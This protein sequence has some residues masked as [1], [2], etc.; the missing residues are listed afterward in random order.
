VQRV[1]RRFALVAVAGELATEAGLTGWAQGEATTAAAH[2][3][4][5]WIEAF[6]GIGNHE[7][8]AILEHVRAFIE[9]HGSSRFES[10][11]ADRERINNRVGYIRQKAGQA[12]EY[13]IFPESFKR[14]VCKGF[15]HRQ[16]SRVLIEQGVMLHNNDSGA[17]LPVRTPDSNSLVR[18]YILTA[19]SLLSG[20]SGTDALF[21]S[22]NNRNNRNKQPEQGVQ[23]LR[24]EK[25]VTVTTVTN[26]ATAQ[27]GDSVTAVTVSQNANR[28]R[29]KPL[30]SKSAT[31]ATDRKPP[32]C[33]KLPING[34][35][36]ET[37]KSGQRSPDNYSGGRPDLT[38][39][40]REDIAVNGHD[41]K[42]C[43]QF[44]T[45]SKRQSI[46]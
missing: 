43:N 36:L 32:P 26:P 5:D 25:A 16:V 7:E 27:T 41:L 18:M 46:R 20:D 21:I 11:T 33:L 14:E 42:R 29:K 37:K 40:S 15:D 30:D 4:R 13:L 8:R 24:K 6:G 31:G 38:I 45:G 9:A 35:P 1:A 19:D 39:A 2:C 22:R 23:V 44:L 17:T 12:R 10:M 34:Y 3:L 28:N